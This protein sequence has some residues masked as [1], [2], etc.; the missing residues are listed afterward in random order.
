MEQKP[1]G[2]GTKG[3]GAK[4]AG[5]A[6]DGIKRETTLRERGASMMFMETMC[7]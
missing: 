4:S 1:G 7:P 5:T 2:V 3:A 6:G